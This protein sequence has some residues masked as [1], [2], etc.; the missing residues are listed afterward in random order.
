MLWLALLVLMR[1]WL[2]WLLAL[3]MR[4]DGSALLGLL[5]PRH[6]DFYTALAIG[7]VP[8]L[9]SLMIMQRTRLWQHGWQALF[10]M[11]KPVLLGLLLLD[12]TFQLR[13][14]YLQH[15]SFDLLLGGLVLFDAVLIMWLQRSKTLRI[16]LAD[17]Q[18]PDPDESI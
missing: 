4:P 5:Y 10:V 8:L 13:V 16:T 6:Q 9:L 12:I 17:W 7:F 2:A 14:I 1:G 11:I 3:V 15:F 18:R